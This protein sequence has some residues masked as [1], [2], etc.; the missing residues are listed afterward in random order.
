MS[1]LKRWEGREGA[2]VTKIQNNLGRTNISVMC[3]PEMEKKHFI[4][5]AI[6]TG[7]SRCRLLKKSS[8]SFPGLRVNQ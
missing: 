4:E 1:K 6:F 2:P 7:T 8:S 5:I 3:L